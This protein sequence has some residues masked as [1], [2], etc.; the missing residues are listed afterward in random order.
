MQ[1]VLHRIGGAGRQVLFIHGF[2]ADRLSWLAVAPPLTDAAEVYAVDL[3]AHGDAPDPE[4]EITPMVMAEAV[5]ASVAD[6]EAP[7]WLV[8]HSLGGMVA[9]LL[10]QMN[11]TRF[12]LLA[13]IAPA[14]FGRAA[15]PGFLTGFS[16]LHTAEDARAFLEQMVAKP[17]HIAPAMVTH[18]LAG[19]D[20]KPGRRAALARLADTLISLPPLLRADLPTDGLVIWGEEDRIAPPPSDLQGLMLPGVG[21]VPQVEAAMAVQRAL[22]GALASKA[23]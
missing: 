12:P 10:H 8:G 21:H 16:G 14:G 23:T 6:L 18:V 11:P 17:R 3:P 1:A 7:I 13:L 5:Q 20:S 22:R 2:G 19:L 9:H 4:G 15:D